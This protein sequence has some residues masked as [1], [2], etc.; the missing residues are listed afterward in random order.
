MER[1]SL[2]NTVAYHAGKAVYVS[3]AGLYQLIFSSRLGVADMF[4]RWVFE[5]VL[6][7][8]QKAGGYELQALK[9]E[10]MLKD[11]A[12]QEHGAVLPVTSSLIWY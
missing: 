5:E 10:M 4:R 3:E 9:N 8:I 2:A 7:S 12:H 6:P 11:K 1:I